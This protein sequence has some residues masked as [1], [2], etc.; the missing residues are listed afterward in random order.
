[1]REL[2]AAELER[3]P[4]LTVLDKGTGDPVNVGAPGEMSVLA[5]SGSSLALVASRAFF[6]HGPLKVVFTT[7]K[8]WVSSPAASASGCPSSSAST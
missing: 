3:V 7:S 5:S 2:P 4:I 8:P 1:M 6:F